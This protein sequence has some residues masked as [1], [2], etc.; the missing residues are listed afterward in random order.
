M[1]AMALKKCGPVSGN[2][3]VLSDMPLPEPGPVQVRLKVSVCGVCHTD[4]H[5]VEGELTI[6]S[7]PLVPG[8]QV[9]GI[10]DKTGAKVTRFKQGDRASMGWI[11]G[12]CGKCGF[13]LAGQENLCPNAR[14]TGLH[15]HGGFAE[16]ALCDQDFAFALPEGFSDEHAA[17]LLCAGIIGYRSLRLSEIKPGGTLGLFGFGASAHIALQI[18]RY[19]KCR[20]FV[21]T[22]SAEHRAHALKLGAGWAGRAEDKPPALLDAGITFAPAGPLVKKALEHLKPGGTLAVNA[23]TMSPIP[24]FDYSSIYMERT[25]RSV[26]NYTRRDGEEFLTLAAKVPVCTDVQVS[27]LSQAN[28]ALAALKESRV[29]GALVLKIV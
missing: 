18:A 20:V 7:L 13:C 16:Y 8:H 24:S 9:V 23:I 21:F 5:T 17:P 29:R 6:P 11:N 14:F 22:R 3:L 4:L 27:G 28:Q 1:K 2:P 12:A 19:W 15:A 26:A 10:V 25:L